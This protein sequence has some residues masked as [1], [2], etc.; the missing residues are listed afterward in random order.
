VIDIPL[1]AGMIENSLCIKPVNGTTIQRVEI[2]PTPTGNER[3]R[4][5]IENL[6]EQRNRLNDRLQALETREA[7]FTSAAKSQSG[8]APRKSKSNPDPMQSIRQGTDFAMT[9]LEAVYTARRKS[10]L[11]IKRLDSIIAAARKSSRSSENIAHITV[12]PAQGKVTAR[13]AITT[14][15]WTPRYDIFLNHSDTAQVDL[16]GKFP[17]TMPGHKLYASQAALAESSTA[18]AT[19]LQPGTQ[20][21]LARYN[22]A[23]AQEFIGI[24]AVSTFSFLLTNT[25]GVHLPAGEATVYTRGEYVGKVRFEGLSS[26]RSTKVLSGI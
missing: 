12:M 22:P 23:V 1:Q 20:A 25:S 16:Y 14:Q 5:E 3:T 15:S 17:A 24:G 11:E 13:Y 4:K 7:I 18:K 2:T 6:L 9:Q 10:E 19:P 26:G 21:L 8:K